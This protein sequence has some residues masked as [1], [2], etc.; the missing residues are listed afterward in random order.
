MQ[1]IFVMTIEL[2]CVVMAEVVP[3]LSTSAQKS[4]WQNID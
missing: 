4:P 1:L 3:N 2:G